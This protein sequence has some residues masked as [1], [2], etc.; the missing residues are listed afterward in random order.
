M[1]HLKGV[2]LNKALVENVFFSHDAHK[3]SWRKLG[4]K[5]AGYLE[6]QNVFWSGYFIFHYFASNSNLEC[7]KSKVKMSNVV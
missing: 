6:K 3:V 2:I 4:K 5:L 7:E 1:L